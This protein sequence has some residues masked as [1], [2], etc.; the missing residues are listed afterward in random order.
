MSIADYLPFHLGCDFITSNSQGSLNA[1]TLK[2]VREN[3]SKYKGF[4]LLLRPLNTLTSNDA[5]RLINAHPFYSQHQIIV[6]DVA[7]GWIHF[8][9]Q[10]NGKGRWWYKGEGYHDLVPE[11]VFWALKNN[12]DY[13]NLT[14]QGFATTK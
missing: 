13:F 8:K 5:W 10:Y 6:T 12:F 7:N 11:Q 2:L 14:E 9:V 1:S 4:K 3:L